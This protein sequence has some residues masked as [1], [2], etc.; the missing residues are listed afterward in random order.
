MTHYRERGDL[1][2]KKV[3]TSENTGT[4]LEYFYHGMPFITIR[5]QMHPQLSKAWEHIIDQYN[6]LL[7]VSTQFPELK[8]AISLCY[9]KQRT[10]QIIAEIERKVCILYNAEWNDIIGT[11]RLDELVSARQMMMFI[12]HKLFGVG[13]MKVAK[14]YQRN[15]ATILHG[16][17]LFQNALHHSYRYYDKYAIMFEW[18]LQEILPEANAMLDVNR[19]KFAEIKINQ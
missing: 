9:S 16:C 18:L 8:N 1:L 2:K 3:V 11:S 15:H 12:E 14:K 6:D 19:K 4:V 5:S 10:E 7:A 17:R 13:C